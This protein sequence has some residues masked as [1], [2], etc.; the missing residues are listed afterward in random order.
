MIDEKYAWYKAILGNN[1]CYVRFYEII[2]PWETVTIYVGNNGAIASDYCE[3]H[4]SEDD[5]V[6]KGP[7]I[8]T[9]IELNFV[10]GNQIT[11]DSLLSST[12]SGP[13]NLEIIAGSGI[14]LKSEPGSNNEAP[15]KITISAS[16]KDENESNSS[17]DLSSEMTGFVD[18]LYSTPVYMQAQESSRRFNEDIYVFPAAIKS[19]DSLNYTLDRMMTWI[20]ELS[21]EVMRLRGL[22][23][24]TEGTTVWSSP[25][26]QLPRNNEQGSEDSG[27]SNDGKENAVPNLP[28]P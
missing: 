2:P 3:I 21:L 24:D 26:D 13:N 20:Q 27:D 9:G 14:I 17:L 6:P 18:N 19:T 5:S 7:N 25:I 22:Y 28:N 1:S 11:G 4:I 15:H 10:G 12:L 16:N 23:E 8:Y